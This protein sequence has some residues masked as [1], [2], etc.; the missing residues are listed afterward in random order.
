MPISVKTPQR[1]ERR[2]RNPGRTATA[3]PDGEASLEFVLPPGILDQLRDAVF[4]RPQGIITSLNQGVDRYG[5][6]PKDL[7]GQNIAEFYVSSSRPPRVGPGSGSGP[8]EGDSA[9]ARSRPGCRSSS[10]FDTAPR[11][12]CSTRGILG[13]SIDI[14]D[15]QSPRLLR[16]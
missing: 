4:T 1:K 3:V 14:A 5:F 11:C 9:A 6:V 7:I 13:F 15:K 16:G 12:E 8:F 2:N 10:A